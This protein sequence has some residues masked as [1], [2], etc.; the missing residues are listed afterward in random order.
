M[1]GRKF[2]LDYRKQNRSGLKA[3]GNVGCIQFEEEAASTSTAAKEKLERRWVLIPDS[4]LNCEGP[5]DVIRTRSGES[6]LNFCVCG[7]I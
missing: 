3:R 4:F 5:S 6:M 2:P 7:D 1:Y